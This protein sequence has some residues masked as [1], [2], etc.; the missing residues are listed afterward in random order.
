MNPYYGTPYQQMSHPQQQTYSP[1][2]G[3]DMQQLKY[4]VLSVTEPF[5]QHAFKETGK[6]GCKHGIREAAAM[7]YLVGRGYSPKMAYQ[8][9][10]SWEKNEMFY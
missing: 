2:Y 7:S 6:H 8:I 4:Q 5:V 9:V 1:Q 10:E 3:T